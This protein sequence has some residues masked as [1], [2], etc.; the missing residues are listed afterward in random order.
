M[1]ALRLQSES[2]GFLHFTFPASSFTLCIV[3]IPTHYLKKRDLLH[4]ERTPPATL[5]KIGREFL[6]LERYSDALDFFEKARDLDNI[7]AIKRLALNDGDTFLL[8]RLERFDRSLISREDW[9]QA[10][11]QALAKG[12]KSMAEFVQRKFAPPPAAAP[13]ATV[14]GAAGGPAAT[15]PEQLPGEAPLA[16]V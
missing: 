11:A 16:E 4:S 13:A 8:A 6:A 2:F 9:D 3:A 7:Q 12:K 1:A 15:T 10:A 14:P 5:S